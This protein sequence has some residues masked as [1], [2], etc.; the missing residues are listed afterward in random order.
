MAH[1]DRA[2]KVVETLSKNRRENEER[3]FKAISATATEDVDL[4]VSF[5]AK[6]SEK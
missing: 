2:R 3:V 4:L 1:R 6:S 5:F